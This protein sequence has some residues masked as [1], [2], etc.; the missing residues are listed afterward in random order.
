MANNRV[1][2][3]LSAYLRK[4]G[5]KG[6]KR[7]LETMTPEE[8][9]ALAKKAAARSAEVRSA[10]AHLQAKGKVKATPTSMGRTSAAGHST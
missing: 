2:A 4:L 5:K 10:K 3:E 1:S 6:G 7:R 9:S 8:R